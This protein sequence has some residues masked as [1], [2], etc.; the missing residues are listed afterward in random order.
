[1]KLGLLLILT[2]WLPTMSLASVP[3]PARLTFSPL[4][5][6]AYLQAKKHCVEAELRVAFPINK[7]QGRLVIPSAKGVY[8]LQDGL[9]DGEHDADTR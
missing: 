5:R 1:M 6:A 8:V 3:P 2:V 9:V 7:K 4:T